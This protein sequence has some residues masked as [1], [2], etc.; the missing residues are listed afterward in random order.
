MAEVQTS[1]V[2]A[3][4]HQSTWDHEI[5]YNDRSSN[6]EQLLMRPFLSKT[7]NTN[8]AAV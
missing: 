1:E 2:D 5:L 7:K 8:M 4:L 6:D 3:K